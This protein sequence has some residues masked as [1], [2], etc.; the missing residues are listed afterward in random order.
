M[1]NE[2]VQ[3][4]SPLR[5][6]SFHL[7]YASQAY[8]TYAYIYGLGCKF[9]TNFTDGAWL[10]SNTQQKI[11]NERVII[12]KSN[13][14]LTSPQQVWKRHQEKISELEA[15]GKRLNH[16]MSFDTWAKLEQQFDQGSLLSMIGMGAMWLILVIWA[17]YWLVSNLLTIAG[18]GL[19]SVTVLDR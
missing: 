12:L 9:Y 13:S 5:I 14:E 6:T 10:V 16:H 2:I 8:A 4:E 1:G 18:A 15:K 19:L 3:I 7:M 17:V 11:K